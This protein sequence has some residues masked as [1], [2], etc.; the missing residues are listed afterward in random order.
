MDLQTRALGECPTKAET[1]ASNPQRMRMFMIVS[2]CISLLSFT[3]DIPSLGT[4]SLFLSPLACLL[5]F[6]HHGIATAELIQPRFTQLRPLDPSALKL[7]LRRTPLA[8]TWPM[9]M[10]IWQAALVWLAVST[11]NASLLGLSARWEDRSG[12]QGQMYLIARVLAPL[13]ETV[14]LMFMAAWSLRERQLASPLEEVLAT[15]C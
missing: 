9:V 2:S 7:P 3:L 6:L 1:E 15:I 5:T 8:S 13:I 10:I 11:I 4:R 14:I 12:Y